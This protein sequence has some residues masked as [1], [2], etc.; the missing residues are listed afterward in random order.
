MSLSFCH[1]D[2]RG[3]VFD[4]VEE[5]IVRDVDLRRRRAE[6]VACHSEDSGSSGPFRSSA[7]EPAARA[8]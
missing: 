7:S 5:L 2:R 3:V 6:A 1:W 4:E 8:H